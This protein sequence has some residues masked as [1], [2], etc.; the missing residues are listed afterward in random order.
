MARSN[1]ADTY[2][3]PDKPYEWFS[4][5]FRATMETHISM[6]LRIGQTTLTVSESEGYHHRGDF[7]SL[8]TSRL[9]PAKYHWVI[10]RM[11]K[12][13]SPC[14]YDG[15]SFDLT[16]PNEDLVESIWDLYRTTSSI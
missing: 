15:K 5:E 11:H 12:L 3:A 10:L 2:L 7:Y 6:L 9:I 14:D 8:L 13:N 16:I 1:L 4:R